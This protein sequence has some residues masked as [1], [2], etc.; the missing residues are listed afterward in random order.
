MHH[1]GC[2]GIV[3]DEMGLGKTIQIVAFLAGLSCS[4]LDDFR[5]IFNTLG[6]VLIVCPTTIM[7]QWVA[8]IHKWWSKFRVGVLHSSG[9]YSGKKSNLIRAI[10][11]CSGIL[12]TSYTNVTLY[13][14]ELLKY[15]WHYVILDE[16]HR[17]KNPDAQV[18]LSCKA[19]RTPHRLILTGSPIQNNLRELWSLF[20]FVY[21]GKLG[22]LPVFLEQFSIP[23]TQGGYANATQVQV[24]IAYKCASVLRDTIKPYLLRRMKDDVKNNVSLPL[25]NEQVLFC[26]LTSQ[27]RDLYKE[28]LD[29]PVVKDILKGVVQIF[30]GL[31]H[32]RK[33]CNHPDIIKRLSD[34]SLAD[35]EKYGHYKRS[36]KL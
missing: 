21:P 8:E 24:E 4:K 33:I 6:P 7:H 25:K 20:D 17:I 28:Y 23:I 13:L 2:G 30:V 27:Q 12:I 26:K 14:S 31:V 1:N 34:E 22:T 19:F 18:T 15:E 29:S 36:G 11:K 5:D 32:L 3:G 16:G 10:T 9:S 35:D